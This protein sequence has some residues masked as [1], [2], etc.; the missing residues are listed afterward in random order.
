MILHGMSP[1]SRAAT[2]C[3]AG[4]ILSRSGSYERHTQ[5]S[6]PPEVDA[7]AAGQEEYRRTS[8][9]SKKAPPAMRVGSGLGTELAGSKLGLGAR[10]ELQNSSG[11]VAEEGPSLPSSEPAA[12]VQGTAERAHELGTLAE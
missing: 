9:P 8:I 5:N 3:A 1:L 4:P 2:L 6:A 12:S 11:C 10:Q 7:E